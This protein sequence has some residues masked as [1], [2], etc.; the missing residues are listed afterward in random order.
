MIVLVDARAWSQRDVE[1]LA[2]AAEYLRE[3]VHA[4]A[5]SRKVWMVNEASPITPPDSAE[6]YAPPAGTGT[7]WSTIL[8]SFLASREVAGREVYEDIL[9]LSPLAGPLRAQ[10]VQEAVSLHADAPSAQVIIRVRRLP[11]REHLVFLQPLPEE[12]MRD[13]ALITHAR[14]KPWPQVIAA[15]GLDADAASLLP[16]TPELDGCG[17]H[18]LPRLPYADGALVL[19]PAALIASRRYKDAAQHC[20]VEIGPNQGVGLEGLL[21]ETC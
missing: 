6:A 16:L 9:Y 11:A 3:A 19:V 8:D 1:L 15:G 12:A 7:E 14:L 20:Y 21:Y 2:A 5:P 13:G 4:A 17:S 10:T 18:C